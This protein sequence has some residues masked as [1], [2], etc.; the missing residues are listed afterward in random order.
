VQAVLRA[1]AVGAVLAAAAGCAPFRSRPPEPPGRFYEEGVASWYGPGFHGRRT[2]SGEVF[3]QD[4]LTAAHPRLPFGARVRV[5][6]VRNGRD[7]VV[8]INDRGPNTAD[9]VIDVSRAAAGRLDMIRAGV[10]RVRLFLL[11]AGG[12][13]DAD[14]SDAG[15]TTAAGPGGA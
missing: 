7:V 2:A 4:A 9:R 8:R 6:N 5:V 13:G 1:A 14:G 12:R 3:D 15:A 10:A 11:E